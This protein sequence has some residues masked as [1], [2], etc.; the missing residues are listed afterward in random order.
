[1]YFEISAKISF[2]SYDDSLNYVKNLLVPQF[3][4]FN[5]KKPRSSMPAPIT[6]S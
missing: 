2:S 3:V 6:N 4:I 1:M 5:F